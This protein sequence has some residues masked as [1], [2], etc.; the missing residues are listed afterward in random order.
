[1]ERARLSVAFICTGNI[2]R[3]PM[4]EKMFAHHLD[5]SGLAD[6]VRVS[7]AGTG[8]WHAGDDADPRTTA[9]L[10]RHGYPTGHVA[11]AIGPAHRDADLLV[12]LDRGHERELAR[13]GVPSDRRRL[14]RSFDPRADGPDVPDPY[15]GTTADFEE[16]HDQIAAAIPGLLDWVRA[17]L[18]LDP[19]SAADGRP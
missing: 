1:M 19:L 18:D 7:S 4:A 9:T 6:L 3:S 5:E 16:V 11:A 2:C 17:A 15:Y 10:R 14:L 8:S 13:L 12:A